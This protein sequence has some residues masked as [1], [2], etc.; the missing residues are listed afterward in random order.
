M[1]SSGDL[2]KIKKWNGSWG[3]LNIQIYKKNYKYTNMNVH[4]HEDIHKYVS[5]EYFCNCVCKFALLIVVAGIQRCLLSWTTK[6]RRRAS[7]APN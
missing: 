6:E 5:I 1:A 7:L 4:T 2:Y 3:K